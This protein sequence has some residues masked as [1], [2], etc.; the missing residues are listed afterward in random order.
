MV[1]GPTTLVESRAAVPSLRMT[2][3][4]A[5]RSTPITIDECVA[6]V[7]PPRAAR[8]CS[9]ERFG[10]RTTPQPVSLLEY[11]AYAG[12]AEKEMDRICDEIEQEVAGVRPRCSM[13]RR[14]RVGDLAVV[15]RRVHRT[16][17]RRSTPVLI[18]RG[19]SACRF[20][21]VS[22]APVTPLDRVRERLKVSIAA[23]RQ[24]RL[25]RYRRVLWHDDE[26]VCSRQVHGRAGRL[27]RKRRDRVAVHVAG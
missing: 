7:V 27:L 19:K 3:L 20:R 17:R 10:T 13:R 22:T 18:D 5:I 2:R 1:L 24:C 9:S 6:A 26:R 23:R 11:E 16:A 14:A 21:S 8:A 25:V 15:G 12:M 4:R